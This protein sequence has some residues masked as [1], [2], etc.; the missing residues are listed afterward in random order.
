[1]ARHVG[2]PKKHIVTEQNR[3]TV[4][5]MTAY[6]IHREDIARAIGC[7]PETISKHY[8][9]EIETSVAQANSKVAQRLFKVATE[10]TGKELVTAMIFWLKTR[11]RWRERHLHEHTGEDGKP[12][13]S[14]VKVVI[15]GDDTKL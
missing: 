6:G 2:D 14:T 7:S 10:G 9:H 13:E 5:A 12:I 15:S 1:M 8:R 11:A 3:R 4:S